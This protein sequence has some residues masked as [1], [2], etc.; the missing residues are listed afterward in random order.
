MQL[1]LSKKRN[2]RLLN[3][4]KRV[5]GFILL[6]SIFLLPI[7]FQLTNISVLILITISFLQSTSIAQSYIFGV[8]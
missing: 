1:Q 7:L 3:F 8:Q 2:D 4:L 5:R 6:S